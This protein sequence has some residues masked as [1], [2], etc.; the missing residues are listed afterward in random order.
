MNDGRP[1]ARSGIIAAISESSRHRIQPQAV[2]RTMIG[3]ADAPKLTTIV[4]PIPV[5]RIVP[6]SPITKALHQVPVRGIPA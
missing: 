3:I 2:I 1:P 6:A 4:G 5:T